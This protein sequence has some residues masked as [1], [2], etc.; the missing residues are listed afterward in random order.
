[1]AKVL[2]IGAL[3]ASLLLGCSKQNSKPYEWE[4]PEGFPLPQVPTDNPMTLAKIELGRALF[5]EPALSGNRAMSCSTC[6][7][8]SK[9]FSD[10]KV[11]SS[12][13]MGD[14]LKRN[15][16]AL[17][18]IAY[19]SEFTWAHNGLSSIEQQM[20]IPLFSDAPVEM[21]AGENLP[22]ILQR[23]DT[24]DYRRLFYNAFGEEEPNI[25]K[26]VKAISSF[27]RSL[28]SF[29]S[30]F[31]DYAYRAQDDALS[32]SQLRGLELFF[33]ERFECFHCHGGFNFTQSSKHEFQPLDLQPFHNTGLYNEDGQGAF[34]ERDRGLIDVTHQAKDMGRFRAPTLRNI[35]LS[36]PYMHDGSIETLADVI[37]FYA[38]GGRGEGI[39]SPLKSQFVI[40]FRMSEEEKQDLLA[41]LLSLSDPSFGQKPE[42]H[43]PVNPPQVK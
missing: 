12:G 4:L 43:A 36:A 2:I 18:N 28:T 16:L 29:D 10:G 7:Q 11:R 13:S 27:V 34:P 33:S 25:D 5:Y 31:D 37:D 42:H 14:T 35:A 1:M 38:A 8:P 17:V 32:E 22:A 20:M 41:F 19:N 23:F 39:N 40:G 9:A 24:E 15:S 6:H 21:G 30:P 26:I 3:G